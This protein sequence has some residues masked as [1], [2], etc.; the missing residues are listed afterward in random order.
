MAGPL[1]GGGGTESHDSNRDSNVRNA[2]HDL[3][4]FRIYFRPVLRDHDLRRQLDQRLESAESAGEVNSSDPP[5]RSKPSAANR[6]RLEH[7]RANLLV[8]AKKHKSTLRP[9]GTQIDRR[10]RS[11]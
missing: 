11:E 4:A 6:H 9:D 5:V 2:A 1:R 3:S 8:H 10:L 7:H